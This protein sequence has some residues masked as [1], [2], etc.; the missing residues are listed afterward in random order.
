[1]VEKQVSREGIDTGVDLRCLG[2]F[3][4]KRLLLYDRCDFGRMR[5]A[6]QY[7]PVT[8]RVGWD[9]GENRHRRELLEMKVA[10]PRDRLR[11]DERRVAGE[12]QQRFVVL[13]LLAR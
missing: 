1:M 8:L 9:G 7:P 6:P 2:L 11:P 4:G 5:V 13:H 12:Y 3:S 10:H